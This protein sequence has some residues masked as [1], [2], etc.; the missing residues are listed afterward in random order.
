MAKWRHSANRENNIERGVQLIA[1][2][3]GGPIALTQAINHLHSLGHSDAI[4]SLRRFANRYP[5]EPLQGK[6][7]TLNF[8][9]LIPLLFVPKDPNGKLPSPDWDQRDFPATKGRYL[10]ERDSWQLPIELSD[11]IPFNTEWRMVSGTGFTVESTYLIEWANVD[12]RLRDSQLTPS[13]DPFA[14]AL[15][16]TTK[17]MKLEIGSGDSIDEKYREKLHRNIENHMC[18]QAFAMISSLV[19]NFSPPDWD[20]WNGT[21]H[22]WNE[23]VTICKS[24]GLHWDSHAQRYS[25][26]K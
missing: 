9:T 13:D 3:K 2:V 21:K 7:E 15:D 6:T 11:D 23:L 1:G 17:Q 12:G 4:E 18:Q 20:D 8:E 5:L 19:P 22:K 14:A 16:A 26:A 10:L 24:R 25:F